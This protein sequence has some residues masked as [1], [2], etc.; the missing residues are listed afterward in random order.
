MSGPVDRTNIPMEGA[1]MAVPALFLFLLSSLSLLPFVLFFLCLT[2]SREKRGEGERVATLRWPGGGNAGVGLCSRA[3]LNQGSGRPAKETRE[4]AGTADGRA[5]LRPWGNGFA[6]L[7][8]SL[9]REGLADGAL[10]EE[11]DRRPA[12][13]RLLH[14]LFI[15]GE[16]RFAKVGS[17]KGDEEGT[18]AAAQK[19]GARR[20][21]RA[22]IGLLGWRAHASA[23]AEL[24][25][26]GEGHVTATTWRSRQV[27]GG[28][29]RRT[30]VA[31]PCRGRRRVHGVHSGGA[32]RE[33]EGAAWAVVA[34]P[35]WAGCN[36]LKIPENKN[37]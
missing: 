10:V 20:R 35:A 33:E 6:S 28:G 2:V 13:S 8:Q 1:H 14:R 24:G 12:S 16:S 25:G 23:A 18:V 31:A 19:Q 17:P 36:I 4:E 9:W 29:R 37:H 21:P 27:G 32:H 3:T 15:G 34:G 22:S 11:I 30:T 26:G 7:R 5:Q